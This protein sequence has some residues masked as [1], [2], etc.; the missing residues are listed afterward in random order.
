MHAFERIL[1]IHKARGV[2]MESRE[3]LQVSRS[4]PALPMSESLKRL[5]TIVP[6]TTRCSILSL[7][8]IT[9]SGAP[10]RPSGRSRLND[11][12]NIND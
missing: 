10:F 9:N 3:M 6:P 11:N 12:W 2:S 5:M 1:A 4:L 7:I 8:C